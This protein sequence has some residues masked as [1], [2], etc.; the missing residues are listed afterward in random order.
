MQ[1]KKW[2]WSSERVIVVKVVHS[3]RLPVSAPGASFIE[4]LKQEILLNNYL[5]SRNEQDT[6]YKLYMWH[7]SLAGN[8][9]LV[10]VILLF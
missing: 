8:L 10:S 4:L 3:V 9:I 6:S 5:L 7:D 2:L 1:G